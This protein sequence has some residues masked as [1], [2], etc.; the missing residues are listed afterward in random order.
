M[1]RSAETTHRSFSKPDPVRAPAPFS[2]LVIEPDEDLRRRLSCFLAKKYE[3]QI[4]QVPQLFDGLQAI[5][6]KEF[7]GILFGSSP[8]PT[9]GQNIKQIGA[10]RGKSDAL[11]IVLSETGERGDK[12]TNKW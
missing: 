6:K 7:D 8:E 5:K 12:G 10:I 11:L 9:A 3:W 4:D 1:Q 2:V